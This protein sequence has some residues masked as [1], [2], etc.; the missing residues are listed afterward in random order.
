MRDN[1]SRPRLSVPSQF[2]ELGGSNFRSRLVAFGLIGIGHPATKQT[3]APTATEKKM[4]ITNVD[5]SA[6]QSC[7]YLRATRRSGL[8]A[9]TTLISG[10]ALEEDAVTLI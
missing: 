10:T 7:R 6:D 9:G 4:T 8:S 5:A 1:T 3:P 2:T